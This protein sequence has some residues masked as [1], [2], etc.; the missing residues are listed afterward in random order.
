MPDEIR[1]SLNEVTF[2][3]CLG[4]PGN[5]FVAM[6]HLFD[7]TWPLLR[8]DVEAGGAAATSLSVVED[9][10]AALRDRIVAIYFGARWSPPSAAFLPTLHAWFADLSPPERERFAIV[11]VSFDSDAEI[12][13]NHFAED[14]GDWYAMAHDIERA[15]ALCDELQCEGTPTLV[16]VDDDGRVIAA[17]GVKQ[18][19]RGGI[20]H[21]K[22][23]SFTE[24]WSMYMRTQSAAE[25]KFRA[26]MEEIHAETKRR[27]AHT[28]ARKKKR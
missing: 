20:A 1:F 5:V 24:W 21:S 15:A 26:D 6:A 14:H 13:A 11:Y 7:P 8:R 25:R 27:E 3:F 16:V 4:R 17:D 2:T 23:D 18:L 10:K 12:F 22:A 9:P 28:K 19:E